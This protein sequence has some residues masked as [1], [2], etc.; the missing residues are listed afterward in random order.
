MATQRKA[1]ARGKSTRKQTAASRP[2]RAKGK[3]ARAAKP[4][5]RAAVVARPKPH[6][7]TKARPAAKAAAPAKVI[8]RPA[9]K[10]PAPARVIGRPA[11]KAPAPAKVIGRPAVK[12]RPRVAVARRNFDPTVRPLGVIPLENRVRSS[13]RAPSVAPAPTRAQAAPGRSAREAPR[14]PGIQRLT[15]KDHKEFE[16]LLLAERQKIMK[17]MGH[18][19]TTVLKVNQR[20]SAGDLS[21][22][23]FH[24]ADAGTDAMERE[25]AFLLASAEGR[26]LME[27]NEALRRLYRGEF[28]DCEICGQP[29]GRARLEAML[30]ARLCLACKE[31]EE[32]ASRGAP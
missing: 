11:V 22:Y 17:E 20:E 31:K 6:A 21:R 8:G 1:P 23:S 9:V 26:L 3:P 4:R 10:A 16:T 32:R 18:L 2:A 13:E 28:G 24:M 19:E 27:I 12:G 29:I 30:H 14:A 15:E 7:S 5:A 25:K